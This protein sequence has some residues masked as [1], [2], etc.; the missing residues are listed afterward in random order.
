MVFGANFFSFFFTAYP[1]NNCGK[2]NALDDCEYA[3][4][5]D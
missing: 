5:A 1:A 4:K 3:A 2:T